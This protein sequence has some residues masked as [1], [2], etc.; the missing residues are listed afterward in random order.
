MIAE[1]NVCAPSLLA[2]QRRFRQTNPWLCFF[3]T[4]GVLRFLLRGAMEQFVASPRPSVYLA[5]MKFLSLVIPAKCAS[6][7][8]SQSVAKW[9]FVSRNEFDLSC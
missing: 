8:R 5:E 3:F 9:T 6:K 2:K 4:F 7:E 1:E